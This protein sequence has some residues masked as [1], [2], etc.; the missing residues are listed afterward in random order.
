MV[1]FSIVSHIFLVTNRFLGEDPQTAPASNPS[2]GSAQR[3]ASTSQTHNAHLA[4]EAKLP[5]KPGYY[6]VAPTT[7]FSLGF[8]ENKKMGKHW[9]SMVLARKL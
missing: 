8:I 2:P 1:I 3:E 9:K 5:Q 7:G 4:G 6:V